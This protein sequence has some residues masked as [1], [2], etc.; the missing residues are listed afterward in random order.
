[1]AKHNRKKPAS[2][3][4][5]LS[6]LLYSVQSSLGLIDNSGKR[7]VVLDR[8]LGQALAVHL[9]TG[10]LHTVHEG[11]VV[12]AVGSDSSADTGDPQAAVVTLLLLAADE[13]VIAG[14]HDLLLG[15]LE[16]L[17]LGTPV[18][19]CQ[20][21]GSV[22]SLARHHRAFHSSHFSVSSFCLTCRESFS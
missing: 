16:V 6:R 11:G 1:M 10:L 13:S 3:R 17:G 18:A 4:S 22:S 8:H 20:L 19:L 7:G 12:H 14:L 2:F 9:D 5:G 21:Q 15:H